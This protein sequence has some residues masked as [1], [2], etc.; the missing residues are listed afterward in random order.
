MKKDNKDFQDYFL[1][2]NNSDISRYHETFFHNSL[3][4]R[5]KATKCDSLDDYYDFLQQHHNERSE[6]LAS[7]MISYS[8]FFRNPLTWAFME[9]MLLA[10]IIADKTGN[11]EIRIW[12]AACAAGQEAYSMAILAEEYLNDKD[13]KFCYRIFATDR[14]KCQID[15]AQKG[16]YHADQLANLSLKYC[17]K[18]FTQKGDFYTVKPPLKE[19]IEFSVLDLFDEHYS[20][21][22]ASIF[23][24]FDLVI[25][26][27]VLF[28]YKNEYRK[29]IIDKII[30][31][32]N[33]KGY[34]IVGKTEREIMINSGFREVYPYSGIFKK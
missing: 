30:N 8:A 20:C 24:D 15:L 23:G 31:S 3:Q 17:A 16:T 21:P 9:G 22:P 7:L 18:W 12:S 11:K 19:H 13:C 14:E 5:M 4:T 1:K 29:I 10:T 34:L 33:E 26:A 2:E 32:M 28:Y 25:C 6:L 27:N